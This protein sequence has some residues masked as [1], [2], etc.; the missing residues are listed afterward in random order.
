MKTWVLFIWLTSGNP[1][2]AWNYADLAECQRDGQAYR[3]YACVEVFVPVAPK[4]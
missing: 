4:R 2:A 3:R 1:M